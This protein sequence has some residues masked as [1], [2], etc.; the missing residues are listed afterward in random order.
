M[1]PSHLV[2]VVEDDPAIAEEM[3]VILDS[4]DCEVVH[5]DNKV[6]ALA[7]ALG[8]RFCL[9][10]V[11]LEIRAAPTSI[12]G[13]V[14]HGRS[15][16]REL[17]RAEPEHLGD[18]FRFPILVASGFARE[19]PEAIG[20]MRDGA[21]DIIHKPFGSGLVS[22]KIRELLLKSQRSDHAL[23]PRTPSRP[24]AN[25]EPL[26]LSI[27]GERD[28]RRTRVVLGSTEISLTD[29]MLKVLLRLIVGK[30]EGRSV[31]KTELGGT[32]SQG[33][34]GVSNLH[35]AIKP[36]LPAD[37][38]RIIENLYYGDYKLIDEVSIG[39]V[40]AERL[41]EIGDRDITSM[42]RTIVALQSK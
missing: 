29:S 30:L 42:A 9:A 23:C 17:R 2:L 5:C 1:T 12:R 36:A 41:V 15:L 34:K 3:T 26:C 13:H 6:E 20:V 24:D 8:R 21:S 11:D 14:E 28:R 22:A 4:L 37:R 16:V 40:V 39:E 38:D 7:H 31:H 35:S 33:F 10:V 18:A 25:T 27:P 32:D 19:M